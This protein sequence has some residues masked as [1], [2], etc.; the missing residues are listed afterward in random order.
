MLFGNAASADHHE[1]PTIAP[2]K[3]YSCNFLKGKGMDDL[4]KV[5]AKW[6]AWMDDNDKNNYTAVTLTPQFNDPELAFDVAW[7]GAWP[8]GKAGEGLHEQ[9]NESKAVIAEFYQVLDCGVHVSFAAVTMNAPSA[10]PG[11]PGVLVFSNYTMAKGKK[12]ADSGHALRAWAEY[13]QG[14]GID[15]PLWTII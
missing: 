8:D 12:P 6:N 13:L 10:P 9:L 3:I 5:T 14:S 4:D 11:D 1:G 2:V 15:R 7:L